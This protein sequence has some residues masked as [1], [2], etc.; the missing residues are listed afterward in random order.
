[1]EWIQLIEGCVGVSWSYC[2]EI[3]KAVAYTSR[4]GSEASIGVG[5]ATVQV[6]ELLV[7]FQ[8]DFEME[9]LVVMPVKFH[10]KVWESW[11]TMKSHFGVQC[12]WFGWLTIWISPSFACVLEVGS[13][14][15]FID[16]GLEFV[17]PLNYLII[18]HS[19]V[20][21]GNAIVSVGAVEE[22]VV[23]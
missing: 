1:M 19:V 23:E 11:F 6:L 13:I 2:C 21:Y 5:T 15:K 8:V 14:C 17:L 16:F 9:V 7:G 22:G 12:G 3:C 20:E 4:D 10:V 18:C